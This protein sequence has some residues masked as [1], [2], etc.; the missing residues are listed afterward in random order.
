[1]RKSF[2]LHTEPHVAEIGD[3][4]LLF[5]P[6]VM[7]DAFMDAYTEMRETQAAEGVDVTDPAAEGQSMKLA[8]RAIREFLARFLMEEEQAAAFTA[9]RVVRRSDGSEVGTYPGL[10]EAG[11]AAGEVEGGAR[12]VDAVPLP[13]RVLVELLYWAVEL[14]GGATR[15][16]GPSSGSATASRRGGTR[17]TA[18]S[19]S[20]G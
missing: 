16:T 17:G 4:E 2:A 1:M 7:G 15:P 3:L 20:R 13:S 12:V 9:L 19:R 5:S 11:R 10:E 14:Y 18:R 8:S 6:E